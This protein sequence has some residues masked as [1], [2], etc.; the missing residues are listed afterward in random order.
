M[1]GELAPKA[2]QLAELHLEALETC[3]FLPG[4]LGRGRIVVL[5]KV[6]VNLLCMGAV[7]LHGDLRHSP[8]LIERSSNDPM[9]LF[10][11]RFSVLSG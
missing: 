10:L 3:L 8:W 2:K 4:K 7:Q 9:R 11:W 5:V 6:W 1:D